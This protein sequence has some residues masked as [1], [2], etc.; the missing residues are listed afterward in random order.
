MLLKGLDQPGTLYTAQ[1]LFIHKPMSISIT[2]CVL[3]MKNPLVSKTHSQCTDL[4]SAIF[5]IEMELQSNDLV[6]TPSRRGSPEPSYWNISPALSLVQ[7]PHPDVFIYLARIF[8]N[9]PTPPRGWDCT[10]PVFAIDGVDDENIYSAMNTILVGT[11]TIIVEVFI[12]GDLHERLWD[13][14]GRVCFNFHESV[15]ICNRLGESDDCSIV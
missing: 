13:G 5:G 12:T 6:V 3:F 14:Y 10:L 1:K 2:L 7:I 4:R 15:S 11:S 8:S 9:V